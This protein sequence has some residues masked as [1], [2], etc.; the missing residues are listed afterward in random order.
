MTPLTST[1][2]VKIDHAGGSTSRLWEIDA[3]RGI[4]I[5]LVIVYHLVWDLSYFRLYP[6][7]VLSPSWQMFARSLG[8]TFIFLLG[9]S[10][11]LSYTHAAHRHEQAVP[12]IKYLRRGS[13]LFG[14]GLVI[15]AVTYIVIGPGF[16]VFGILHLLGLSI[17]LA[18]PFLRVNRWVSFVA[19]LFLIGLGVYLNTMSVSYP[20]LIWLGIKQQGRAMVDY[21]SLL[22]WFGLTLLGIFAGGS[23]YPH[24]VSQLAL[25]GCSA[26]LPVRGLCF[27]GRHTLLIYLVHQPILMGLLFSLS[28]I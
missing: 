18:Y 28:F 23:L 24:G 21:Y 17:V 19:G 6:V 22:P 13:N 1:S 4:A 10:L 26:S 14:L 12:F 15:T 25:P 3:L 2:S 8:S 20:W 9:V 27:L 16:V 11:T 5:I 7:N